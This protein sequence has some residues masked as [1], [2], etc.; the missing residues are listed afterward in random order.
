MGLTQTIDG[1]NP[2]GTPHIVN[3][4]TPLDGEESIHVIQT[5]DAKGP[6]KLADGTVYDVT[7]PH[8]QVSEKDGHVEGVCAEIDKQTDLVPLVAAE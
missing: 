5:G 3:T 4:W 2:D 8:I 1:T 7:P 6:V